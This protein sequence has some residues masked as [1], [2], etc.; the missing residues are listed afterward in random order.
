M[1]TNSLTVAKQPCGSC[2]YRR[3]VPSGIWAREE[4][5][6]L[7]RYDGETWEQD[8]AIFMC[9]QRD[10]RLCAGWL[11]CHDP[12][13]LLALRITRNVDPRVFDYETDTPVFASGAEARTHGIKNIPR[14]GVRARKMVAGLVR[15]QLTTITNPGT[16]P[17][18]S[19][20]AGSPAACDGPAQLSQVRGNT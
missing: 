8:V 15:R 7:P 2:P 14:P 10:G 12:R 6:K 18:V 9:H 5:D 13:E 20:S 11:A 19:D 4:Y 16:S 17:T 1:N 3:D